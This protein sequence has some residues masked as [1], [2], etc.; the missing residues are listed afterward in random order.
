M[1]AIQTIN[2]INWKLKITINEMNNEES[3]NL[4][5]KNIVLQTR[6]DKSA[7]SQIQLEED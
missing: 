4:I 3:S 1:A 2:N 5:L 6:V 7:H